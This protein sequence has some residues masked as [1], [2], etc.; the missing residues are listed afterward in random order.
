M[1]LL[2]RHSSRQMWIY[3]LYIVTFDPVRFGSQI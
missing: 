3:S 1:A 2:L